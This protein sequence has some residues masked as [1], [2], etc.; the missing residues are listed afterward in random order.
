LLVVGVCSGLYAIV[1]A[2]LPTHVSHPDGG[3]FT[4][5]ETQSSMDR[6]VEQ[7]P[8]SFQT[9]HFVGV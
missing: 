9:S 1:L 5:F 4:A 3:G 6:G 2:I 7:H 8:T